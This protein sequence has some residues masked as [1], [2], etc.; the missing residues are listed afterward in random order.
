MVSGDQ[1]ATELWDEV[2]GCFSPQ[3]DRQTLRH[4]NIVNRRFHLL[5]RPRLF[6]DFKFHP[7]SVAAA[8]YGMDAQGL[9]LPLDPDPEHLRQRLEF[10]ASEEIVPYVRHC[11]VQPLEFEDVERTPPPGE[12]PYILLM[13]FYDSLPRFVNLEVFDVFTLHLTNIAITNLCL[14]PKL[15]EMSME[16]CVIVE[17]ETLHLDPS[18]LK[19]ET[20]R[21]ARC[22]D[23]EE[24]W[25]RAVCPDVLHA[26]DLNVSESHNQ[27]FFEE[28]SVPCFPN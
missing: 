20:F 12:D 10:W 27:Q 4:L 15:T 19:L 5:S 8:T 18:K 6:A 28:P 13:A 9:I 7:Y 2:V 3:E 1:I 24:W 25:Y 23:L 22:D 14:L 21:F 17:G 16:M 26:L 11:K